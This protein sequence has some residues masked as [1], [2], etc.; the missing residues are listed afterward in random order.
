MLVRRTMELKFANKSKQQ[1]QQ[2]YLKMDGHGFCFL[3]LSQ[4]TS[5]RWDEIVELKTD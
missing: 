3:I 2:Q 5:F 1:Q 4:N